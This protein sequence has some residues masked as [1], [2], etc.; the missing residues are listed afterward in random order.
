MEKQAVPRSGIWLA[1]FFMAAMLQA[2]AGRAD[3]LSQILRGYEIAPVPLNLIGK[4]WALV[5]LGSD[6]VNSTGCNDCHI[7]Q[8]CEPRAKAV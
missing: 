2:S 8:L 6:L 3:E 1:A 4:D 7:H 5:G